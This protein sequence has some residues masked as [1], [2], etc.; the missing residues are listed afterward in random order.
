MAVVPAIP[1][2][3]QVPVCVRMGM[4][5]SVLRIERGMASSFQEVWRCGKTLCFPVRPLKTVWGGGPF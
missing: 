2:R 5:F 4:T 1:T 3:A